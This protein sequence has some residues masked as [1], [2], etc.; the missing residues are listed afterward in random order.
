MAEA[1]NSY[2]ANVVINL[3]VEI[4]SPKFTPESYL[5]P[6]N[7]TFTMIKNPFSTIPTI[8]TVCELL[9]TIE[10]KTVGLDNTPNKLLEIVAD[11]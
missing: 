11:V 8:A 1:F 4:L 3:T 7:K 10:M 9:K 2:F 5:S 6:T